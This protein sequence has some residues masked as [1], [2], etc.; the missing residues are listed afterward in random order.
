MRDYR[1]EAIATLEEEYDAGTYAEQV[2]DFLIKYTIFTDTGQSYLY[3]SEYFT[4]DK[5]VVERIIQVIDNLD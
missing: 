5:D 2:L 4:M 1:A 3:N